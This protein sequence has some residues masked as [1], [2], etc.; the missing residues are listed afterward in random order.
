M[1]SHTMWMVG[2]R[3]W[4]EA[5]TDV[6]HFYLVRGVASEAEAQRA[7]AHK[8]GTVP[9]HTRRR[10]AELDAE[11]IQVQEVV[12]D[13]IGRCRLSDLPP[14]QA[15]RVPLDRKILAGKARRRTSAA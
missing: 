11:W 3:F 6:R 14:R 10:G 8:A 12:R 2:F 5:G 9:E 15:A 7:A 4:S 13:G 1:N